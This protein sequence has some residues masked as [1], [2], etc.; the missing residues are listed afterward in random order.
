MENQVEVAAIPEKTEEEKKAQ[1]KANEKPLSFY[2]ES[3]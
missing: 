3:Y 1:L 2:L